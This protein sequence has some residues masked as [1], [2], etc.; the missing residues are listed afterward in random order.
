MSKE[1]DIYQAALDYHQFPRPGKIG[2]HLTKPGVTQRDLA[3]AY[4][5]GVAE[6]C[7]QIALNPKDAYLYT[8]KGHLV[9]VI[10]NGTAVLGLGNIGPLASKPVMEGKAFLFHLFSGLDAIDIE[11][12]ATDP[13]KFI[14]VVTALEPSF[15]AI[16]LEDIRAPECFYIE[17]ELKKRLSIPVL[18]DD[19]HGTAMTMAAALEN[20]LDI[21]G[22][23]KKE[24]QIVCVGAGA[25]GIAS[26]DFLVARG[27]KKENIFLID[28][29]GLVTKDRPN[30]EQHKAHYAQEAT[31]KK[32]LIDVIKGKDIFIGLSQANILSQEMLLSM[33]DKPIVFAMANPDPEIMP[34]K[35]FNTRSDLIM[36][37]GRSDYPNQVNNVLCFPYIFKGAIEAG[38]TEINREMMFAVVEALKNLTYLPVPDQVLH[39]YH[40]KELAFGKDYIL[41]KPLDHRLREHIT[42]AVIEAARRSGVATK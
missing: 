13:D 17:K 35:A 20:A 19:Q 11:I 31:D 15:G 25:A 1:K 32:S 8:N 23:D 27:I 7:R 3:L 40:L 30:L 39:N 41:P 33:A 37:T 6:P 28:T 4:S 36:A 34:E 22:K 21:Q 24:V 5:P 42:K 29:K 12:N 38:A 26:M 2:T 10:S 16:N 9:A 18:H 14:E